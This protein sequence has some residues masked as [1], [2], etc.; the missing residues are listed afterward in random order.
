MSIASELAGLVEP[1]IHRGDVLADDLHRLLTT[2]DTDVKAL[3]GGADTVPSTGEPAPAS[4]HPE[5]APDQ[6]GDAQPAPPPVQVAD[7]AHTDPQVQ[8]VGGGGTGGT[9]APDQLPEQP[10]G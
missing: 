10:A 2:I 8:N 7:T 5:A 4:G 3:E 9:V 1:Y 6:Q